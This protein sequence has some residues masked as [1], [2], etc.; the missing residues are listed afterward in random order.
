[1]F[2]PFNCTIIQRPIKART[3]C[4]MPRCCRYS[5]I[6]LLMN[7]GPLSVTRISGNPSLAHTVLR[8]IIML[9]VVTWVV[10]P[11]SARFD[12]RDCKT[13]VGSCTVNWSD[14][15]HPQ[16]GPAPVRQRDGL[17][18]RDSSS[19]NSKLITAHN[20]VPSLH[21]CPYMATKPNF[22]TFVS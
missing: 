17:D 8:E 22:V 11:T 14:Y 15:I 3:V 4:L 2:E 5:A 9:S 21:L 16:L 13:G 20:C 19:M 12:H 6:S 10:N 18:T 1:M 7:C